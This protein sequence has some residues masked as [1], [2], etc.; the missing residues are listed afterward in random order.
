MI[1]IKPSFYDDFKCI[2]S[3]CKD[4]CC[5]GWEIDVDQPTLEKYKFH[6]EIMQKISLDGTPHFVLGERD[7]C[8]FLQKDNLCEIIKSHRRMLCGGF[9]VS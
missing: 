3:R 6:P 4:N 1:Y 2:A 5:I 7:R 9:F 8:P